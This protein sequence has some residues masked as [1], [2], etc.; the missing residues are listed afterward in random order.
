MKSKLSK[1]TPVRLRKDT[2]PQLESVA[3][4]FGVSKADIV[5]IAIDTKLE[6]WMSSPT[7]TINAK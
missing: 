7:L 5:R 2:L 1:P 3:R 4:K 6:E